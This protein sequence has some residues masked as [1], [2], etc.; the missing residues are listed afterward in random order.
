MKLFTIPLP[1]TQPQPTAAFVI[2][3][4]I[5]K[6]GGLLDDGGGGD[7]SDGAG[8]NDDDGVA[9]DIDNEQTERN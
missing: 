8:D 7:D 9:L 4:I 1:T 3:A 2:P 6:L 5:V